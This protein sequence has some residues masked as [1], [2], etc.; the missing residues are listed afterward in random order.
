MPRHDE[1]PGTSYAATR[2]GSLKTAVGDESPLKA[3]VVFSTSAAKKRK[4][5]EYHVIFGTFFYLCSKNSKVMEIV[6]FEVEV[7]QDEV[8]FFRKLAK[9]MGWTVHRQRNKKARLYD[10]ETGEYLNDR[11]MKLIENIRRGK[12]P[13]YELKSIE[14]LE[15]LIKE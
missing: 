14:D 8:R 3:T 5:S 2:K 10:P 7:P 9:K 1:A 15:A 13:L 11:T 4:K 6:T 12:E